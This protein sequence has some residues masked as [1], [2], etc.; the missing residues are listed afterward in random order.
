MTNNSTLEPGTY[1]IQ[2]RDYDNVEKISVN[3]IV[4]P[5]PPPKICVEIVV[6]PKPK[7]PGPEQGE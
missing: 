2:L 4:V 6:V 3:T 5:K 7:P 1:E